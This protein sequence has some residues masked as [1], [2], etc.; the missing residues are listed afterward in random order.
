MRFYKILF[1]LLLFFLIACRHDPKPDN[2][3]DEDQFASLLVDMHLA[4]GYLNSKVQMPDTL[5][6]YGNGLYTE[7]FRKHEVDSAAFRK[8]Y[9][10]YSVHLEQ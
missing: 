3:I 6:Y 4:D 10:Y 5:S 7:I 8:S 2:L 9:Q 1:S